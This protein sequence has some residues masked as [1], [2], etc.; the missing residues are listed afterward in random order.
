MYGIQCWV[1]AIMISS[2][3]DII[4]SFVF[5]RM[6]KFFKSSLGFKSLV[7]CLALEA[8]TIK[9]FAYFSASSWDI[10]GIRRRTWPSLS[11]IT[12]LWK[13]CRQGQM[14]VTLQ[15]ELPELLTK[16]SF[17]KRHCPIEI[18]A[19]PST[20]GWP[21]ILSSVSSMALFVITRNK[22]LIQLRRSRLEGYWI[23]QH[24]IEF[25]THHV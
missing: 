1:T 14:W 11:Q 20:P 16:S 23:K 3:C 5:V 4:N 6:R 9:C 12:Y 13:R 2:K 21:L 19:H 7:T 18:W 10:E 22:G 17:L 15:F 8:K 25:I 24:M